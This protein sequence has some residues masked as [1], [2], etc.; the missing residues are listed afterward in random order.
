MMKF[1]Q[2]I[3]IKL[4]SKEKLFQKQQLKNL[5]K[6]SEYLDWSLYQLKFQD[7]YSPSQVSIWLKGNIQCLTIPFSR[8]DLQSRLQVER[9]LKLGLRHFFLFLDHSEQLNSVILSDL[10]LGNYQEELESKKITKY[11][12]KTKCN[13]IF[14][15]A[16][17]KV[18]KLKFI[19]CKLD[20]NFATHC[21]KVYPSIKTL[22]FDQ[23]YF[24]DNASYGQ[25]KNLIDLR[26]IDTNVYRKP[27]EKE[28]KIFNICTS[29]GVTSQILENLILN[30]LDI[31]GTQ[32]IKQSLK[33]LKVDISIGKCFEK[34]S[35][36]IWKLIS[37]IQTCKLRDHHTKFKFSMIKYIL[38]STDDNTVDL[39]PINL[40]ISYL[41]VTK[42][43][44]EL[45][46]KP[47]ENTLKTLAE[48]NGLIIN[49]YE[50]IIATDHRYVIHVKLKEVEKRSLIL[51]IHNKI[52]FS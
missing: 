28:N 51:I 48:R 12:N 2:R 19:K 46:D 26:I 42:K 24:L 39:P 20:G 52:I 30:G 21:P 10:S 4:F 43:S 49:K 32:P 1:S 6:L 31:Q 44:M 34:D 40:E 23:C 15:L 45:I 17:S 38:K 33:V 37:Q 5:E 9:L 16:R 27:N 14:A 29:K 36:N 7:E 50:E 35:Q 47:I 11:N 18:T 22:I 3:T 25:F 13:S 8:G 41:Q